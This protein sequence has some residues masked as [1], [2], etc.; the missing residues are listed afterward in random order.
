MK[1][2]IHLND[3]PIVLIYG[4]LDEEIN[5]DEITKIDYSNLYGESVTIS[6][7]LNRIG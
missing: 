5:V 2:V 7:I 3:K 6:V 1:H 4:D